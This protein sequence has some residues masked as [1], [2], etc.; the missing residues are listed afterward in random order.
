MDFSGLTYNEAYYELTFRSEQRRDFSLRQAKLLLNTIVDKQSVSLVLMSEG[1]L[2]VCQEKLSQLTRLVND[3]QGTESEPHLDPLDSRISHH[4]RRT[5]RI[6]EELRLS[7]LV[8]KTDLFTSVSD[9]F[10]N[11]TLD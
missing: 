2:S 10:R 8:R 6:I 4:Q 7:T 5:H 9:L 11:N 1:E 3:F